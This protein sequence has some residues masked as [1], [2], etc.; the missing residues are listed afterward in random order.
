MTVPNTNPQPD[1][2]IDAELEKMAP[3]EGEGDTGFKGG[4]S[5]GDED[6]TTVAPGPVRVEGTQTIPPVTESQLKE[7]EGDDDEGD[8]DGDGEEGKPFKTFKTQEEYDEFVEAQKNKAIVERMDKPSPDTG[9][10]EDKPIEFFDKDWKPEDPNDLV[11]AIV[12]NPKAAEALTK[13]LAPGIKGN[14]DNIS[15][16]E[17]QELDKID[18]EYDQEY[19]N[20]ATQKG[21]PALSTEEGQAISKQIFSI[22]S[23]YLVPTGDGKARVMTTNEMYDVWASTPKDKGGG[24]EQVT[25]KAKVTTRKQQSGLI[26]PA[27]KAQPSQPA[28]KKD[29]YKH[30]HDTDMDS[31]I[32]EGLEDA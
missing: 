14:L 4:S 16:E 11:N 3:A 27:R 6:D 20:L 7:Q 28:K 23:K 9:K 32:E 12:K 13:A 18:K 25:K 31:L 5:E 29:D 17:Q 22:G 19:K 26:T 10:D 21:L 24:L 1:I 2:D 8:D 30:F 15:Q